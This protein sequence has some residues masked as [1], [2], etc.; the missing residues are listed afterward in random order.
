M[1]T[2][3]VSVKEFAQQNSLSESTVR[4]RIKEGA[5]PY[6]QPGGKCK[7][8]LLPVNA[9]EISAGDTAGLGSSRSLLN[10]S[11]RSCGSRPHWRKELP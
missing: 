7:K 2:P 5:L 4:R 11:A 9:L 10:G 1:S 6:Q 3:H 8:L